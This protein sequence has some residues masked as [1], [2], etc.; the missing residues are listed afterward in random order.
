MQNTGRA[1]RRRPVLGTIGQH[2]RV[3]EHFIHENNDG[4]KLY[5]TYARLYCYCINILRLG[6]IGQNVMK[7]ACGCYARITMLDCP[8]LACETKEG[9]SDGG[10]GS[11]GDVLVV[12]RC[13][14]LCTPHADEGVHAAPDMAVLL[15]TPMRDQRHGVQTWTSPHR[16]TVPSIQCSQNTIYVFNPLMSIQCHV[17]VP[18]PTSVVMQV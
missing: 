16:A 15:P 4:T 11:D 9:C 6:M 17:Y 3:Y 10:L 14:R 7:I 1:F 8:G 5:Y 13:M 2:T 12:S 18:C